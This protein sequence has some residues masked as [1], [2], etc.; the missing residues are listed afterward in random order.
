[1][2]ISITD[3]KWTYYLR[4][5]LKKIFQI[6]WSTDTETWLAPDDL[7]KERIERIC[8]RL[9]VVIEE[10]LNPDQMEVF[11]DIL[12]LRGSSGRLREAKAHPDR[13]DYLPY[14]GFA[15]WRE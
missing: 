1:M 7:T 15:G 9:Q 11:G 8:T 3:S 2:S 13:P 12:N 5:P 14:R 6:E 10:E 4:E